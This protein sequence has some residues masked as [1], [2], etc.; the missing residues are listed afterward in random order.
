MGALS[1]AGWAWSGHG[2][3]SQTVASRRRNAG[4]LAAAVGATSSHG[5]HD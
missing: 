3:H 5:M 1:E 4:W 2:R